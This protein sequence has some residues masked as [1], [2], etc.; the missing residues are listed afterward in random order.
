LRRHRACRGV[1]SRCLALLAESLLACLVSCQTI[2][3][4]LD[5]V[6][7]GPFRPRPAETADKE[8]SQPAVAASGPLELRVQD[9]IL[10]A[11][12]QNRAFKVRR[13]NPSIQGTF[14][15]QERAAF[16]PTVSGEVSTGSSTSTQ[17]SST[18]VGTV[19]SKSV[20]AGAG[21]QKLL[22]SGTTVG[23]EGATSVSDSSRSGNLVG[24]R[25][26]L[27][28]TQALLKGYGAAVNLASLRQAK[29]NTLA[30]HYELR[31]FAE[32]LVAQVEQTYWNYAL[33]LRQI[34]IVTESLRL[35]EQ[36]LR[37]TRERINVGKL[38]EI[39]LAAAEAE[40]ALRTEGLIN[41]RSAL[42][43]V[44]LLLLRLLNPPGPNPWGRGLVLRNA[45]A[46]PEVN[47]ED[48]ESHVQVAER[49][50]PDLN[51]ARL[52]VQHGNLEI[53]TTRNGLLPKLDLFVSLGKTGFARSF[54][55]S[56]GDLGGDGYDASFGVLYEYPL[57]NRDAEA[58]H[59]RA[60]L[61]HDQ[62]VEAVGNLSQLVELD[63]RTAHIEV[64]R[65]REQVAATAATRRLQEEAFR[66]ETEKFQVGR[67]T[68]LLVAQA[69]RDL[70]A[71]R[72]GEV[73]AVV[74]YLNALV[75]LYRLDGSLLERRGIEAPGRKPV[76]LSETSAP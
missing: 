29:L 11:L 9:A 75:D 59:E 46:I 38:A 18:G 28:V 72:I 62:E 3:T 57:G 26:G 63:V 70:V 47:L 22:P 56:V 30:S 69:Q 71:G 14:E 53:V 67:S 34:E 37:E 66:A 32:A 40:V 1:S 35:A 5:E 74:S 10:L 31:G 55:D 61:T 52:Q 8:T 39:E 19:H 45:P 13:L 54:F 16:D 12:E 44:R 2:E 33:A 64:N 68:S 15:D 49:M 6:P 51:E 24:Q 50:R 17:A 73:Q 41:A 48:V 43:K 23:I 25:L 65:A 60:L 58:R 36:Q 76:Q 4:G 21:V 42:A 27:S 20:E 7:I